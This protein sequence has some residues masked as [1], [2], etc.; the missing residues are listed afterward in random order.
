LNFSIFNKAH[1]NLDV[2]V[3]FKYNA[4]SDKNFK[5]VVGGYSVLSEKVICKAKVL[6]FSYIFL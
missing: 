2:A 5:I 3:R 1:A 4:N 6:I